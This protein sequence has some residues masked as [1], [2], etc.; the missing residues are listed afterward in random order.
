MTGWFADLFRFAW[1]LLYW[2]TRKSWFRLRRGRS[3]C[4]CQSPSDS[5]RA[6]E[7]GC[8]ASLS[9]NRQGRFR[10]LCPLLVQTPQG[11]RCAAD[12]ADV[13][14]FWGVAARYF[15][16][17]VL[18][19]YVAAVLAVFIFLRTVGYPV[20]IVHVGLPPLW[21]KVGQARGWFFLDQSNRAFA[22]G[23]T[24]E[25][26]LALANAYEFDP[27]NYEAGIA[28]AKN[29]QAGQPARSDAVFRKLLGEH[30]DKRHATAQDWFR[31]LLARGNFAQVAALAHEEILMNTP[32]AGVWMRALLFA[33]RRTRD[34]ALLHDL[35]ARTEPAARAWQSLLEAELLLRSGRTPEA[36]AAL[37]RPWAAPAPPFALFYRVNALIGLGDAYAALDLLARHP[38]VLDA[39]ATVTLRLAAFATQGAANPLERQV[40][41]LLG[42]RL[43]P[44][45]VKILCAQLI[46]F[47]DPV[48]FSRLWEKVSREALPFN[49]TTA[50]AWFSLLATAGAIGDSERL[51]AITTQLKA[52][53]EDPFIA[54]NVVEAFFL[55][56]TAERRITAFLPILPLPLEVTYALLERYLPAPVAAPTTPERA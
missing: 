52:T 3:E 12:T 34:D 13:R 24:A 19:L 44:A 50:G 27:G 21:D 31:A 40:D 38:G 30:P 43:N 33:T 55:G 22:A 7:T 36:R 5:G 11:L 8:E 26:L 46:R 47:P 6:Y 48:L 10:R 35:A 15:G 51:R 20:S 14:P 17:A 39:E 4:P 54:L 45:T 53:S 28:L 18:G 42:S 49:A 25:G 23:R 1:G 56:K 32:H 16:G 9:W 41:E 29:Y 37:E 2:N